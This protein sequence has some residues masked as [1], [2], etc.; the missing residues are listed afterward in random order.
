MRYFG[1][2][3]I[4]VALTI[5]VVAAY[6]SIIGL[7]A[8]FAASMIPVIIMGSVLEVGK[9]TTAVWLHKYWDKA[10]LLMK[11]YLTIAVLLLMFITSMGIFGFLSK[12]HIEQ[13]AMAGE[14]VAQLERVEADIARNKAAITRADEKMIK[15]E[16]SDE[17]I[18]TNIQTKIATEENRI[19]DKAERLQ[20]A[21]AEQSASID[22]AVAP[23]IAQQ[24]QADDALALMNGFVENNEVK[25]IQ[26]LIG[27][28]QD[29]SYGTKTAAAVKV[30]RINLLDER[31]SAL[32]IV[33]ELRED[34]RD[35]ISRL[36]A[37]FEKQVAASNTLI[38]RM[39]TELSV[40]ERVD[41][42]QDITALQLKIKIS[43]E[44]LDKL[45]ET[46]YT[47]ET[48]S[49]KL[50][51]EVGPVKYIAALI[52]GDDPTQDTLEDA[53]RWIIMILVVV[54]DP[55]AVVLVIAGISILDKKKEEGIVEIDEQAEYERARAQRIVDNVP[56]E[57][58]APEEEIVLEEVIETPQP[59]ESH[60]P[61]IDFPT[62][63]ELEIVLEEETAEER[64]I[65]ELNEQR[66]LND[67]SRQSRKSGNEQALKHV[68]DISNRLIERGSSIASIN[69]IVGAADDNGVLEQLLEGADTETLED[70]QIIIASKINQI[71]ESK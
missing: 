1:I 68:E 18:D 31:A 34:T 54:F 16:S 35:E 46:K 42:E 24:Q 57:I 28:V 55:L 7:V 13:T 39:T 9:I 6:Y 45:Y 8:I 51:A 26:G 47:I 20:V 56:H 11:S 41:T 63:R 23:Y 32:F 27:E 49:R 17:T 10:T 64:E 69:D 38:N 25:K 2:W 61:D 43:E 33:N 53:V 14:G 67:A 44:L 5:S 3:T 29:G 66:E 22:L 21:I 30:Y 4:F 36:R 59:I 70:V 62:L 12:A 65:R 71:K 52:Y 60:L 15:L 48:E 37:N 50:E 40:V 58:D 19:A